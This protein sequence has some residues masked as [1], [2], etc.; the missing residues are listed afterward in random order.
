MLRIAIVDDHAM[1]RAVLRQCL[2]D[3]PDFAIVAEAAYSLAAVDIVRQAEVDV[4]LLDIALPGQRGADA[5]AT[6]GARAPALPV[7]PLFQAG[8]MAGSPAEAAPAR[9]AQ[10]RISA[11]ISCDLSNTRSAPSSRQVRR[12][13]AVA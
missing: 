10:Y 5:L 11:S 9:Q 2:C 7:M 4:I 1:V 12:M 13:S 6:L 8:V 3:Q